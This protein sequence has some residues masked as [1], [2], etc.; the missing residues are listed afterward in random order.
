M[1]RGSM[2][3][4]RGSPPQTSRGSVGAVR[5]SPPQTSRGSVGAVCQVR[6]YNVDNNLMFC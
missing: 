2:G 4:V 6:L 1:S 3:A 5:G